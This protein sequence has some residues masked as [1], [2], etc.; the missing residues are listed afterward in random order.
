MSLMARPVRVVDLPAGHGISYGPRSRP[1]AQPDR[2]AAPRLRRRLAAL[3]SNRAE[4]LVRGIR[5][6]LVG[7]VAMDACMADVTDVPGRPVDVDDEFV[8]LGHRGASGS[9]PRTWRGPAPRTP[10]RS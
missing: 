6:P 9:R 1:A 2:D 8:L 4:A 5:V 3:L 10:G 7:N